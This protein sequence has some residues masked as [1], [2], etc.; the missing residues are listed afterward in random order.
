MGGA[1]GSGVLSP[2]HLPR[3]HPQRDPRGRTAAIPGDLPGLSSAP[4]VVGA[5]GALCAT[6]LHCSVTGEDFAPQGP[7][8]ASTAAWGGGGMDKVHTGRRRAA[9]LGVPQEAPAGVTVLGAP[10]GPPSTRRVWW[11]GTDFSSSTDT[12]CAAPASTEPPQSPPSPPSNPT[13]PSIAPL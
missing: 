3:C 12:F 1:K 11:D 9:R 8:A 5:A 6:A 13:H 4:G 7:T 10:Q 2:S